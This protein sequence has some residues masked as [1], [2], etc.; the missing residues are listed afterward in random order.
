[1][2]EAKDKSTERTLENQ[3]ADYLGVDD[4]RNLAVEGNDLNGYIGV[5]PEYMSYADET[6][7]PFSTPEEIIPTVEQ[8]AFDDIQT[9]ESIS[10]DSSTEGEKSKLASSG[11]MPVADK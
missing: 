1:M 5:S 10:G 7:K 3:T 4:A 2:T 11:K 8:L 6:H 9:D